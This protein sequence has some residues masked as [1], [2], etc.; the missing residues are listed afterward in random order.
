MK[1]LFT[2]SLL[3]FSGLSAADTRVSGNT[4]L[5]PAMQALQADPARSPIT[6]WVERGQFLWQAQCSSCHGDISRVKSVVGTFPKLA[7]DGSTKDQTLRN[8]DDQIVACSQR[9]PVTT[10]QTPLTL[11]SESVLALS[12]ALHSAAKGEAIAVKAIEPHASRGEALYTTRMGRINLACTHC[13]DGKVGANMRSEV[14]SQAQPTG[15]PIFKQS[16]Q[17]LGSLDRRLRACYSGVQAPLQAIGSAELR[18]LELYLKV[19]AKGMPID[20]PSLRR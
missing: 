2:A 10:N 20:G 9:Q 17:T 19:R 18:D 1:V 3:C 7:S 16:W 12:A 11:E 5:P 4:F 15:F 6:L 14:I 13:H 8:L